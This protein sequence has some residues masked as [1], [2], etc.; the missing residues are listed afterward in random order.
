MKLHT[1]RFA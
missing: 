1:R